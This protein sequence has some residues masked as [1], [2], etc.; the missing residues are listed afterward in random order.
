MVSK[1]SCEKW[2]INPE[3]LS[4][5][6]FFSCLVPL[7]QTCTYNA[8]ADWNTLRL[9]Q[10]LYPLTTH[11]YKCLLK[12]LRRSSMSASI[13]IIW[14]VRSSS[15][16]GNGEKIVKISIHTSFHEYRSYSVIFKVWS[17]TVVGTEQKNFSLTASKL[18][19]SIAAYSWNSDKL[20]LVQHM[21]RT[22]ISI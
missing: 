20:L 7:I 6:G 5:C 11:W 8:N 2:H 22:I 21:A 4:D 15:V 17:G 12:F 16:K 18:Y 3:L 13:K 1:T 9:I 19:T 10:Q 14:S